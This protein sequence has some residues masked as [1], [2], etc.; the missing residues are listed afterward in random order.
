MKK[1]VEILADLFNNK[2][3]T[4]SSMPSVMLFCA[5]PDDEVLGSASLLCYLRDKL[6][7]VTIT[8]GAPKKMDDAIAAGFFSREAYSK[9]RYQEQSNAMFSA[10][11]TESQCYHLGF[12]DQQSSFHM[13]AIC[14]KILELIQIN[15]PDIVLTHPFEGG[16]P[17]HDTTA[18]A[19]WAA[20]TLMKKRNENVPE[21]I[22]YACYNG[23]GSSEP[24]YFQFIPFPEIPVWSVELDQ[25]QVENKRKLMKYYVSQWKTLS[26]FPVSVERYRKMPAYNFKKPPHHGVLYYEFFD[27]GM[28]ARL[29]NQLAIE[30]INLIRINN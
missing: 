11:I 1:P 19:V 27:W 30:T 28:S 13:G 4:A 12:T 21:I 23:N 24:V 14:H 8:D 2:F 7:I 26:S 9:A 16:H 6:K 17:D 3:C 20:V 22:E 5:H 15:R 25:N 18:F 10:G 29:W